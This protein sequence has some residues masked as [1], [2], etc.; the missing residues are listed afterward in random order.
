MIRAISR[1]PDSIEP[2]RLEALRL[3]SKR[4]GQ[5]GLDAGEFEFLKQLLVDQKNPTRRIAAAEILS[6]W[7]LSSEQLAVLFSSAT[8]DSMISPDRIMAAAQI[9]SPLS[10]ELSR[11]FVS[12]LLQAVKLGAYFSES[13]LNDF[14][15]WVQERYVRE[16]QE[17]GA[18]IEESSALKK[19]R[20]SELEPLL[21]GGDP[22][23]GHK[24][25]LEKAACVTCHRV[26]RTGGL[27]GPDLTR[28][29]AVRSGR[30][31]IESMVIP[32]ATFAQ[33]Y[34]TY[35]V[36]TK[37]GEILSGIRVRQ[38]DDSL[39][40]MNPAGLETRISPEELENLERQPLSMM[41]EGLLDG[42]STAEIRDLFA[43]L[44]NL[45]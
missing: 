3:L 29:G 19:R 28:I 18:K 30:D 24:V 20:L 35:S 44:L 9:A 13:Q 25:F 33:G 17:I 21:S 5:D 38:L 23:R 10:M 41:P 45:K 43:F 6:Q 12:Y 27:V 34:E 8:G 32:S 14:Q 11:L 15:K 36:K 37:S 7:K 26:G 40:I 22:N 1:N 42:L 16:I 4:H 2:R 31:L 39:V